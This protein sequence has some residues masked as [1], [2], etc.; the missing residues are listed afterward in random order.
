VPSCRV[1]ALAGLRCGPIH[2][3]LPAGCAASTGTCVAPLPIAAAGSP[4][5]VLTLT[6]YCRGRSGDKYST[7]AVLSFVRPMPDI[8]VNIGHR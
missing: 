1:D 3:N 5:S 6:D 4:I 2:P 8:R 7:K